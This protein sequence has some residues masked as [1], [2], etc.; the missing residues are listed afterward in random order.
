[1]NTGATLNGRILAQA[2]ATVTLAANTIS[3]PTCTSAGSS[4]SSSSSTGTTVCPILSCVTP[5]IIEQ[6][7]VSPT[8][9]FISWGPYA[10][11]DTFI[12]QYGFE[13]GK[14]LY[15]TNVT[16]FSTTI[17]GLPSNQ[18]IWVLISPRNSCSIA[19]CGESKLVGR[20][21]LPNTGF[22]PYQNS[23]PWYIPI[24]IGVAISTL[25]VLIQRKRRFLSK[26]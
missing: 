21:S 16:G 23:I 20:P 4:S 22:A 2:A 24:G 12:V 19:P 9:I 26:S 11:T 18:P 10:G 17:N 15:S 7:R 3:G 8:S 14:W 6:R 1:M 13:N 5:L 25:F